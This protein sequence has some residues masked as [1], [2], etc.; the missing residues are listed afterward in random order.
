MLTFCH[1]GIGVMDPKEGR[2]HFSLEGYIELCRYLMKM[3]PE[4]KHF[5]WFEGL[6][7]GLFAKLS[8]NTI[9]RSDNIDDFL[10]STVDWKEDSL[11]LSFATT[12][13]DQEGE[14]TSEVCGTVRI[15]LFI[16]CMCG[17]I[18]VIYSHRRKE[19]MLI[20]SCPNCVQSWDLHY[21]RLANTEAL[22][23]SASGSLMVVIRIRGM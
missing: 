21:I 22:K 11:R 9:G 15:N 1:F 12:K 16:Y 6:F 2:G 20:R 5:T 3:H 17:L 19:Y 10:L 4:G 18:N 8:T 7:G 23:R 13:S 14:K